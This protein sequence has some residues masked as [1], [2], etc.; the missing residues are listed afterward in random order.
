MINETA[1]KAFGWGERLPGP[2][3]ATLSHVGCCGLHGETKA[4]GEGERV[5]RV[6]ELLET[7]PEMKESI[8]YIYRNSKKIKVLLDS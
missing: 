8:T 5:I 2:I 1:A 6:L 4:L 3:R 7:G